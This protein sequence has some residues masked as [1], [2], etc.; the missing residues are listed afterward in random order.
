M[1]TNFP[2]AKELDVIVPI[3][4]ELDWPTVESTVRD[5]LEQVETYG[6]KKFALAC[7]GGGWRSTGYPE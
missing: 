4:L 1:K 3:A 7:P 6:V 2:A 5:I